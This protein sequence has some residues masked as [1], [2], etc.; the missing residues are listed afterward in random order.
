MLPKDYLAYKLSGVHC[1]DV[2]DASG[3]L[4]FDVKNKCWSKEMCEICDVQESWLPALYESYD[5]VGKVNNPEVPFLNGIT[6]AAGAGDNAAAAIGTNTLASGT[7]N[8]SLGTSG[9]IFI[10]ND[11][12]SVDPANALHSFAHASGKYHLMGCILSAA[13]CNSGFWR[14]F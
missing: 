11:S 2:S 9:T 3:M 5:A 12:F 8:I 14:I 4:L 6:V 10:A 1:T 7:C 13:S